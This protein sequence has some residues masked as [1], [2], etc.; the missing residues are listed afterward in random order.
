MAQTTR[1]AK[2]INA[3]RRLGSLADRFHHVFGLRLLPSGLWFLV[4][5]LSLP[6]PVLD[7]TPQSSTS[8]SMI[9]PV[10]Q[11]GV[12]PLWVSLAVMPL[13]LY[14][15]WAI[16]RV[17]ARRLGS[18]TLTSSNAP[19]SWALVVVLLVTLAAIQG[20]SMLQLGPL[21]IASGAM[22]AGA[23]AMFASPFWNRAGIGIVALLSGGAVAAV[24][25]TLPSDVLIRHGGQLAAAAAGTWLIVAGIIDHRVLLRELMS[26]RSERPESGVAP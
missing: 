14:A 10:H 5:A 7:L 8:N 3:A 6:R 12:I 19:R 21:A 4:L 23:V 24:V 22:A 26:A 18:V 15:T 2:D 17:Y 25:E 9:S 20:S 11:S 16:H 13:V 1:D